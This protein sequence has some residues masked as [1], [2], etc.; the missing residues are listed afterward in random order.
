M[1]RTNVKGYY[2]VRADATKKFTKE[3]MDY[4]EKIAK[5]RSLWIK[6]RIDNLVQ[7]TVNIT[8]MDPSD[9]K[10]DKQLAEIRKKFPIA[11]PPIL[12]SIRKKDIIR[13]YNSPMYSIKIINES[14]TKNSI[15]EVK[16]LLNKT[17]SKEISEV[18]IPV[19]SSQK[20]IGLSLTLKPTP[21][22]ANEFLNMS[23]KPLTKAPGETLKLPL[24][25]KKDAT[26]SMSLA[27]STPREIQLG[28][29]EPKLSK[30]DY[31]K[32]SLISKAYRTKEQDVK[33]EKA[34]YE[35]FKA[36]LDEKNLNKFTIGRRVI[37][38]VPRFSDNK[39]TTPNTYDDIMA[40]YT[41]RHHH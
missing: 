32:Q 3:L 12:T 41:Q 36:E 2:I 34:L 18:T 17:P 40:F 8:N 39:P 1:A 15:E 24:I 23:L 14:V 5:Q 7:N 16:S 11:M 21:K 9:V 27:S 20:G 25:L 4:I 22:K 26:K 13:R 38:L 6:D 31:K 10:Y 37:N 33:I 29:C 30:M 28:R 35:N 19:L